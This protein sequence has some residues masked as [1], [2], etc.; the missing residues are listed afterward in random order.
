MNENIYKELKKSEEVKA[1]MEQGNHSLGVLG[2]TEHSCRHAVKVA[3]T[4][5]KILKKLGYGKREVELAKVAGL[6][7]DVGNCINRSDHEMCIRDR[8][9]GDQGGNTDPHHRPGLLGKPGAQDLLQI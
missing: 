8:S 3:E 5:G 2:F 9:S 7:H 6:L 4:A 1:Y